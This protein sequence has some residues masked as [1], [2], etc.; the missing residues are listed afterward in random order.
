MVLSPLNPAL[1]KNCDKIKSPRS[2]LEPT[3]NTWHVYAEENT[4][5]LP[6]STL[7]HT[8]SLSPFPC[9]L[10]LPLSLPLSLLGQR[11]FTRI[12]CLRGKTENV[13]AVLGLR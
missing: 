8:L 3:G 7:C 4:A 5:H 1:I 9:F 13:R 10:S 6:L 2:S 11:T 12:A